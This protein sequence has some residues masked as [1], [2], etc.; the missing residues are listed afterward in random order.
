MAKVMKPNSKG[1][2]RVTQVE[3]RELV[4]E[5]AKGLGT[6]DIWWLFAY[7]QADSKKRFDVVVEYDMLI[8]KLPNQ[9]KTEE[10]RKYGLSA[11]DR[12]TDSFWNLVYYIGRNNDRQSN[13]TDAVERNNHVAEH[14]VECNLD[15]CVLCAY[16]HGH[17]LVYWLAS[18]LN[19]HENVEQLCEEL[20]E[21]IARY[22]LNFK[23]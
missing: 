19:A 4:A 9:F 17:A 15:E 12:I 7:L 22:V 1:C 5:R 2:L 16:E 14:I 3:D 23:Q 20:P 18:K 8:D 6:M 10:G 13:T 11:L 21:P